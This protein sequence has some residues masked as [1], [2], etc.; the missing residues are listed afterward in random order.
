MDD[1]NIITLIGDDGEEVKFEYLDTIE[2]EDSEYVV[3]TPYSDDE[4][5]DE[6]ELA[7][8]ILK[9]QHEKDGDDTF[10]VEEN[11]SVLEAVFDMFREKF[12]E[13]SDES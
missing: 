9:I 4:D 7:V 3:L 12:D 11:E 6:E 2:Y 13:E 8:D 10:I 5:V 1:A